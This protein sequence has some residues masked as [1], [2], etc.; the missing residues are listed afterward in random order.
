MER[1]RRRGSERLD[2]TGM[3]HG[4]ERGVTDGRFQVAVFPHFFRRE[5]R[6]KIYI[7]RVHDI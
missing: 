3:I 2:I 6:W 4:H 5:E 1:R 7:Y